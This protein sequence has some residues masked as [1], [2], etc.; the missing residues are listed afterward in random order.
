MR[1]SAACCRIHRQASSIPGVGTTG[2][3]FLVSHPCRRC[4]FATFPPMSEPAFHLRL[5]ILPEHQ[6]QLWEEGLDVPG[7][8][9]LYGGTALALRLGH[10]QSVD[11]DFFSD[12][13]FVPGEL[14]VRLPLA[15]GA[16]ILQSAPNTL[17]LSTAGSGVK[18]S[19]LGGI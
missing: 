13:P 10:R 1:V 9:V 7:E 15:A 2:T 17:T 11:F 5:E 14:I 6:R 4:R 18:F 3:W 8:F 16:T 19:F 12:T